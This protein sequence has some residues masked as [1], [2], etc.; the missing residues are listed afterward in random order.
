MHSVLVL[1]ECNNSS[2]L[3]IRKRLRCDTDRIEI[4]W[5]QLGR[6]NMA[7]LAAVCKLWAHAIET[8]QTLHPINPKP[9][10]LKP[11]SLMNPTKPPKP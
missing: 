8:F 7:C 4:K 1:R 10:T 3:G 11:P 5:G 2:L 6:R 9:S